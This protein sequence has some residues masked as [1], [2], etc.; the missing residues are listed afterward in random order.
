MLQ[1]FFGEPGLT[2]LREAPGRIDISIMNIIGFDASAIGNHEFDAGPDAFSTI[3]G[4]DIRGDALGDV[5]WLG[6]QFP[7][8][9][10][11]LDFSAE[12]AL[13]GLA[14]TDI[15][16]NTDFQ[17]LP[18]DLAAAAA[19][20]KL[21]PATTIE[22]GGE[23]IGVI[24]AT[25]QVLEQ[26]TSSGN[27]EVVGPTSNDIPAL[28]GI[29]QPIIDAFEAQGINKIILVSHLQQVELEQELAGT[30]SGID[31][32]VAGGSDVLQA[33]EDDILRPGDEIEES[34]PFR[35]TDAD[36]N[37]VVVVGTDG[38]YT[39]VGRL[40]VD[41]DA[42]GV[43]VEESLDNVL[44]GAYATIPEVVDNVAGDDAFVENSKGELVMRLTDAILG[45]VSAADANIIG[46]TDVFL[47]GRRE[48]VRT[49]ETNL[50]NLS[51]DA[52]LTIAQEF[53]ETVVISLKNGGGIRAAIGQIVDNGDGTSTLVPPLANPQT[54]K[55]EG[56]VSQLD[57]VNTLRFN[58]SLTL[59][60]LTAGELQTILE[61]SVAESTP[62]N[63]PG[64]FPQIGGLRFDVDTAQAEGEKIIN[65]FLINENGN[66][67]EQLI[68]DKEI[69]GDP[70]RTVRIVTLNFLAD[71]GD[72][73]PFPTG[74][75]AARIDLPDV[76]TDSGAFNFAAPG[77]E[78][79]A[80]AE[81]FGANFAAPNAPFNIEET[82][83]TDDLRIVFTTFVDT[84][85]D[86]TI[87]DPSIQTAL[88]EVLDAN[89]QPCGGL[90]VVVSQ[91]DNVFSLS[92]GFADIS[93]PVDPSINFGTAD[94]T[95]HFMAVLTLRLQEEG[96]LSL[97]DEIGSLINTDPSVVPS[98]TTI[99]QLLRHTSGIPNFADAETYFDAGVS[100][101]F[102]D[103]S[104]DFS[105]V[106]YAPIFSEF[107]VPQGAA[108]PGEFS[109]SNTNFLVLGEV[110][111]AIT[112][113][114]IQELLESFILSPAGLTDLAFFLG[115]AKPENTSTFFFDL[116]GFQPEALSDQTSILSSTGASG[117][118]VAT[119]EG[120]LGF[121]S[122]LLDGEIIS[123]S[124]IALLTDFTPVDGRLSDAYGLGTEL[125]T[126]DIDDGR[127]NVREDAAFIGHVGDVNYATALIVSPELD[128]LAYVS[129]NCQ[130][131]S[132]TTV[133]EIARQLVRV[134]DNPRACPAV[135]VETEVTA[136][137]CAGDEFDFNGETLTESGVFVDTL[138]T[139]DGCDSVVV[140]N[141][142]VFD[143]GIDTVDFAICDNE[144][145]EFGEQILTEPG[146]FVDTTFNP[147]GCPL[148]TVLNLTVNPTAA[149]EVSATITEGETFE[150]G[151]ESFSEAGT[152]EVV[153]ET[154]LGCDSIVTLTLDVI[155][156]T[157]S[158]PLDI[159]SIDVVDASFNVIIP[160][161]Q[162]GAVINLE[163]IDNIPLN[164]EAIGGSDQIESVSFAL[165]G[166]S[167]FS[168]VENV[169]P[170]M[171]FGDPGNN[172]DNFARN[173]VPGNYTLIV[174]AF[175]ADGSTGDNGTSLV[176]NFQVV[177]SDDFAV[178]QF[179]LVDENF[180]VLIEGIQ[181]GQ[182]ID[183]STFDVDEFNIE[184][185]V[186][187]E[188]DESV[189]F[190]LAGPFDL[191]RSENV[192]PYT[193]FGDDPNL[194]T[195]FAQALPTGS[196]SLRAI[197]YSE[198]L[199]DLG[200]GGLG[201]SLAV[202]FEVVE[203]TA[204]RA[205]RGTADVSMLSVYPN[206][207][208]INESVTVFMESNIEGRVQIR[209]INQTG[210]LI[211]DIFADSK[212]GRLSQQLKL[213]N[214]AAGI[215][216]IQLISDQSNESLR[217]I[218]RD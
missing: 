61:H 174:T 71:G 12:G 13:S 185:V 189:L 65:A 164:F 144:S 195:N 145:F 10:S 172:E 212:G 119:P 37:P 56:D 197:P 28:A 128:V 14:T 188:G 21:A 196:Y 183:L 101:L 22:R 201:V 36:G 115:D 6:A 25:T 129:A 154:S 140:L 3:I 72:G 198:D 54:G 156:D 116:S 127:G 62:G 150:V 118:I 76:L 31:I 80:F 151:D 148:I 5:R 209:M 199:G 43:I 130:T 208:Q 30:L 59:L 88:Q 120:V 102:G 157:A 216:H 26:I 205:L 33:Q 204:R 161:L 49:E 42:N 27:V 131:V 95:Q 50:G 103:L 2:N 45:L 41:F 214:L 64:R 19:A 94:L 81:F 114:S 85:G 110:L 67:V 136:Q 92:N 194:G 106:D 35:A 210:Q 58:N 141:L 178:S 213:D 117:S 122:A 112:G 143:T 200:D 77:T 70:A 217:L 168:S 170:F 124:S 32:V 99:E 60:T 176:I 175:S 52:N 7:F 15:L 1:E 78:Q 105:T 66:D 40:I 142:I 44:N 153:L 173:L 177:D 125:F 83:S 8:L 29:I 47:E 75:S 169:A 152:F 126:L 98:A 97:S 167:S 38:E 16:P 138:S 57:I 34:Y 63:T 17:S 146:T 39:Y 207:A 133:L 108:T 206:P 135:P 73:Y 149:T 86:T 4:T 184:A 182:V 162:D 179:N 23:T 123:D 69:V 193:I 84:T 158:N 82:P 181:E 111:E 89:V 79:D 51:A 11:N 180:N 155:E 20:P 132:D 203:S 165:T 74:E 159:V 134:V 137:I 166:A 190:R 48:Q 93:Q 211:Q 9:S 100:S 163:D 139:I 160:D 53:D 104:F 191:V 18:S 46:Q 90:N 113:Q 218:V 187:G 91:G 24:G 107:V 109:Y 202:N 55:Q 186:E 68:A 192:A 96:I 171:L 121:M 147:A 215:Y 87:V